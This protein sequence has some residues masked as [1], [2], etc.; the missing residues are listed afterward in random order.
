MRELVKKIGYS[1]FFSIVN[2]SILSL[3]YDKRYLCGKFFDEQRFGYV[4]AWR[5]IW[6]SRK[7]KRKGVTWPVSKYARIPNG[8]NISFDPSSLNVFQQPGTYFQAYTGKINIGKDVWIAQNVGI[9][10]ENHDPRNPE[11]HLPPKDIFIGDHC[12]IG[13]NALILPGVHLGP[14]TTVG[15]GSVVTHSFDGNCVVAGNPARLIKTF[16]GQ[17]YENH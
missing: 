13:M 2:R 1:S 5:G 12:W 17:A 3:F 4:W 15:G 11:K 16:E 6:R 10:T 7:N 9:I 14:Y 8:R